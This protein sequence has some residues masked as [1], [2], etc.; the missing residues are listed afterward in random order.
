MASRKPGIEKVAW[1]GSVIS[2]Q[3]RIRLM[4]SFDERSHSY[5]GYVL[6]V[7]GTI[8]DEPAEFQ[9]AV[10]KG[11]KEKHLFRVGMEVSGLAVPVPDPR[12]ETT[13]FYKASGL[14][15]LKGAEDDIPVGPPFHGVPPGLENYRSRGHRRL[16]ARTYDAKCGTCTWGCRM[17]VEMII[18]HWNPSRRRYRFETFC[19]GP[20]SCSFYR[21]GPTRKVPGR[22]GMSYTEEDWVDEDATAHRGPDD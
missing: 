19:Y 7:E 12:L 10:G 1:S 17:P 9:I 22:K 14:K 2:V 20:K 4:R 6:R 8:G 15:I 11:A 3:P 18:D 16:D 21:A 13:G 5:L